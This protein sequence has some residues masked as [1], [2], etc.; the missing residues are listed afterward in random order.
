MPTEPTDGPTLA[1]PVPAGLSDAG[2]PIE[3]TSADRFEM[4]LHKDAKFWDS[5][6][7]RK[8]KAKKRKARKFLSNQQER[9]S[10]GDDFKTDDAG[11]TE[12]NFY[13][14]YGAGEGAGGAS[15]GL[16]GSVMSS[17]SNLSDMDLIMQ[18]AEL[19]SGGGGGGG[20][21]AGSGGEEVVFTTDSTAD[22]SQ[23]GEG[24]AAGVTGA[25]SKAVTA[26]KKTATELQVLEELEKELGL[27]NLMLGAPVGG[28]TSATTASAK[29]AVT[30]MQLGDDDNLDELEKYLQSLGNPK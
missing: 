25:S 9:F 16:D 24:S 13:A 19:E 4:T 2:L 20:S 3:A 7:N 21:G 28:S 18:L 29:P 8:L 11:V 17:Y 15:G 1:Q 26:S 30:S 12:V 6:A 22:G 23:A 27:D 14:G 5:V 10:I